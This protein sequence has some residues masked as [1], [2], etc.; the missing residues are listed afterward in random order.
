LNTKGIFSFFNGLAGTNPF[1]HDVYCRIVEMEMA[2]MGLNVQY[3]QMDMD[4]SEA[5]VWDG[6][7]RR[8]ELES[9]FS[10]CFLCLLALS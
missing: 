3:V 8:F 7:K 10:F 1:F 2:D 5:K 6:I 4:P 9:A